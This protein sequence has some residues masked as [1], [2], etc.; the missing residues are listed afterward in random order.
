MQSRP[1]VRFCLKANMFFAAAGALLLLALWFFARV[2]TADSTRL[3]YGALLAACYGL[4]MALGVRAFDNG[5]P[6]ARAAIVLAAVFNGISAY[7]IALVLPEVFR[8]ETITPM[9]SVVSLF[10]YSAVTSLIFINDF[11]SSTRPSE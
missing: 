5:L 2:A 11:R 6:L 7:R 10:W 4:V 1:L 3:G 9:V 8:S